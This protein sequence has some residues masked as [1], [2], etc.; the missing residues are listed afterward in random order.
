ML[1]WV[2][3]YPVS[4]ALFLVVLFILFQSWWLKKDF[5]SPATV[6]C[7]SQCI[8]LGIA[9][10]KIDHAMTDFKPTTWMIWIGA[11]VAFLGGSFLARLVAKQK[12]VPVQVV[13]ASPDLRYNWHLHV[14]L[15][16]I[17]FLLFLVGIYGIIQYAG[18]LLLLTGNPAKYMTKDANYGYYSALFCSAP[19]SVLLFAAASFKRFNPE[20]KLRILSRIMVVLTVAIN[21]VA[22]PNR[23][24]LFFSAG[25]IVILFNYLHKRISSVWIMG[26]L[27]LAAAAFIGI[28]SLRDQYGGESVEGK[29]AD[30]VMELPYKYVA[31]N[32]WNFDYGVNPPSDREFHPHTYGIDFFFGLFEFFRI[33]GSFRNSFHWDGLFNEHIE[34]V[35][36]FNTANYLWD[37]YK[38]LYFPG[39]FIFPFLCGLA[40]SVLHLKLC[41]SYTPRQVMFYSFFIY[42][43]GWWFFTPGYKTGIYWVW[44]A[45]LF[46]IST[47]CMRY[48]RIPKQVPANGENQGAKEQIQYV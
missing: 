14:A 41:R 6:Y 26:C 37:V 18:N 25:I 15:S 17:P 36:G 35:G 32:Y 30:V 34:K 33:S 16:F 39:V 45:I 42:F 2:A 3:E 28:S 19:L 7:F 5:F 22:Y 48:N 38:D 13:D 4:S 8:T 31:N 47:L 46:A 12:G 20:K 23:G 44:A 40:L 1:S 21:L 10:L 24:T 27:V 29:A 43:V 11:M 9:Y